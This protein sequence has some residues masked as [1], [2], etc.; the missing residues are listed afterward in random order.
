MMYYTD[1]FIYGKED[2]DEKGN[3]LPYKVL[4]VF[5]NGAIAHGELI[6]VG[7]KAMR[8]KNLF[9]IISTLKYQV[10]RAVPANERL[11]LK[12]WP[13]KPGLVSFQREYL[14]LNQNGEIV[15]KGSANW[16]TISRD[17]RKLKA[18]Q[19]IFPDMEFSDEVTFLKKIPRLR[20]FDNGILLN[21]VIPEPCHIDSNGHVNN[22]HY[23]SFILNA[24]KGFSGI[25]DTFQI[26]YVQEIM[27]KDKVDIIILNRENEVLAKGEGADKK[28]FYAKIQ[29]KYE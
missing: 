2:F 23:T 7:E 9:W 16:L 27:P 11:T 19:K 24:L 1:T 14:I 5:E 13:K 28:H 4:E 29:Y 25:I 21:S 18:G 12:T 26:D 15:I 22:K 17:E 10:L 6:G 20:D 3:L 8:E